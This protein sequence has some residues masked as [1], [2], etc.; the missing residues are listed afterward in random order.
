M[1]AVHHAQ[2]REWRQA[3]VLLLET[4]VERAW[5]H[6]ERVHAEETLRESEGRF[7]AAVRAVSGVLWTNN[8]DGQMEGEQLG[9]AALTAQSFA[10][11]QGYGWADAVHPED[12][13][14]TVEAWN[15]AVAERRTFVF[16]HRLRCADGRWRR[17]A[18]RAI[19]VLRQDGGIREWVGVHTDIT[20]QREA[21]AVLSRDKAG[22]ERL[23]EDRTAAL[24]RE[25]EER[26]K[27][28]EALR[29][30]EKLAALGQLTGG[31]A[32]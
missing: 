11:Y 30:G 28:E 25:V 21:E 13:Q 6:I 2:P 16:E 26:R 22:L 23:V 15:A 24:L 27:V 14:A 5:A 4:V 9:W 18:V 31:I 20:D 12:A 32:H 10:Q 29:Q 19:P 1:M 3:E 17:F 8:A 7:R